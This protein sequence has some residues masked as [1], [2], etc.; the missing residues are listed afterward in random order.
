MMAYSDM[1]S[2]I[3]GNIGHHAS[4]WLMVT[5][6]FF[7]LYGARNPY[8]DSRLSRNSTNR[9]IV[10]V[11]V[12]VCIL[13][14]FPRFLE[15]S[16][17]QVMGHCF[18]GLSLWDFEVTEFG[19]QEIFTVVY[20]W[21]ITGF[22]HALPLALIMVAT[23]LLWQHAGWQKLRK[24]R[25]ALHMT[26]DAD[27]RQLGLVKTVWVV[28]LV[29]FCLEL[30]TLAVRVTGHLSGLK[31]KDNIIVYSVEVVASYLSLLHSSVNFIIYIIY[32][33]DF[34]KALRR[35]FC[36]LCNCSDEFYE[37]C[38]CCSPTYRRHLKQV[39]VEEEEQK[40]SKAKKRAA[41][42]KKARSSKSRYEPNWKPPRMVNV[43][44]L[45]QSIDPDWNTSLFSVSPTSRGSYVHPVY[46][47]GI[48]L[49]APAQKTMVEIQDGVDVKPETEV[50]LPGHVG[51]V[52]NGQVSR[53][54][55]NTEHPW[56]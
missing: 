48:G 7:K 53:D 56:V 8:E 27:E 10:F 15:V 9:I 2:Y 13:F 54:A 42:S 26:N 18:V 37:P 51:S 41:R 49:S 55:N 12:L 3:F 44:R 45:Y 35:T 33:S 17:R 22:C 23:L 14:N 46:P 4:L 16:V 6:G 40:Q 30:P 50:P 1:V 36:C 11:T 19:S 28:L 31:A 24:A 32:C 43:E 25:I 29:G 20:P 5:M 38:A 34:R 39:R 47:N 21:A 52:P